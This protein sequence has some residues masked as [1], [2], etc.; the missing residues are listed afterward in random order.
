MKNLVPVAEYKLAKLRDC[1][2]GRLPLSVTNDVVLR[3]L[4]GGQYLRDLKVK[5]YHQKLGAERWIWVHRD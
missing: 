2:N 5:Y 3:K 1:S 4:F